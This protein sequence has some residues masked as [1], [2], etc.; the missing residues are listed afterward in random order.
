MDLRKSNH[1]VQGH[2][3]LLCVLHVLYTDCFQLNNILYSGKILKILRTSVI[4]GIEVFNKNRNK[5]YSCIVDSLLPW[6]PV[7]ERCF[8]KKKKKSS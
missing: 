3:V 7:L 1:V 5:A 8:I 6:S 4:L 2:L